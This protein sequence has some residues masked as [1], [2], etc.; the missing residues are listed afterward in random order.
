MA[1]ISENPGR[2]M[3]LA[4]GFMA[5]KTLLSAVSLG[6]FSVLAESPLD[7]EALRRRL[8]IHERGTRDFLDALVALQMLERDGAGRY[9]N[10][11][12]TDRFLDRAK[13]S[14]IGGL[15]EMMNARL[16]PFWGALGEALKTGEPQNEAKGGG[17]DLFAALYADPARLE[18]FLKGM[19]GVSLPI[20]TAL[21]ERF[22]WGRYRS[23]ID[24]GTAEGCVPVTVAAAHPH[25]IGGGFDLPAVG[26]IFERYAK[27]HGLG[28]R[29]RFHAGNFHNDPLPSAD[30]LVMG[31]ILH[32]WDLPTKRR[33][34]EK[35]HRALSQGGALIV[36]DMMIDD[37]RRTNAA[38][39]LMSL[40]ML[41]E[42]P[43]GFDYTGA[44]CCLWMREAGF[45]EARVEP[46]VGPHSIAIGIK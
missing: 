33:L 22:P 18:A 45:A 24:I 44:D 21:A 11:P 30:V 19:T 10:T 4:M 25:L 31:H 9:A 6:V 32:D 23:L 17:Q 34:L 29:L 37:E 12:E 16:Y 39:L 28:E 36:Y 1:S 43:G 27:A 8:G 2:I 42:T 13:P 26:P 7:G 3:Q 5:S 40:N 41:V 38:G 14:Y 20:A 15:L 35:A 46:L